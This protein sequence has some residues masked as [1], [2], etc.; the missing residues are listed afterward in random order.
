MSENTKEKKDLNG[1]EQ[2]I[3]DTINQIKY[4]AVEI[5]IHDSRIVQIEKSEK[6]RFDGNKQATV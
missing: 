3:I 2:H 5:L 4:G 1:I 6:I